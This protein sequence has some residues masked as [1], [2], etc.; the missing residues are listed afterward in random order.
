MFIIGSLEGRRTGVTEGSTESGQVVPTVEGQKGT[1]GPRYWRTNGGRIQETGL[2][3]LRS[4]GREVREIG[5]PR[6]RK[7]GW[8]YEKGGEK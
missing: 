8:S 5:P 6:E 3:D 2:P 1:G 4:G 7:R